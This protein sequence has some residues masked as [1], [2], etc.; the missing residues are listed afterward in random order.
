MRNHHP[1]GPL[2]KLFLLLLLLEQ[3]ITSSTV[4]RIIAMITIIT[5]QHM[6]TIKSF[7]TEVPRGN[8][9]DIA[10]AVDVKSCTSQ[11]PRNIVNKS[12]Y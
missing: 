8:F 7:L 3:I 10:I 6:I 11:D 5:V 12:W 9:A 4:I 1:G 2:I